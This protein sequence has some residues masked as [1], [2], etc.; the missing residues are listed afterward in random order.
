MT[1]VEIVTLATKRI[2]DAI[3]SAVFDAKMKFKGFNKT[4]MGLD[5]LVELMK[6]LNL[7]WARHH[8]YAFVMFR[9]FLMF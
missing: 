6:I 3:C 2:L 9:T 8:V 7:L 4:I 5:M 1:F